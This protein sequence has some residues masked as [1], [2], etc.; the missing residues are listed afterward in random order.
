MERKP[1]AWETQQDSWPETSMSRD[2]EDK[3]YKNCIRTMNYEDINFQASHSS[4]YIIVFHC[5]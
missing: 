1:T 2:V 5:G 3:R 4:A